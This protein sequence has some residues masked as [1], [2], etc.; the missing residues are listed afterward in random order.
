[1]KMEIISVSKNGEDPFLVHEPEGVHDVSSH[2]Q[3]MNKL[4]MKIQEMSLGE[5]QERTEMEVEVENI[6]AQVDN[7]CIKSCS[8][9]GRIEVKK[10]TTPEGMYFVCWDIYL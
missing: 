7:M 6:C 1:M 5:E 4:T 2:E 10:K 9:N 3:H 8:S